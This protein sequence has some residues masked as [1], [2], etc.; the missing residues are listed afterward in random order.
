MISR[1]DQWEWIPIGSEALYQ[2]RWQTYVDHAKGNWSDE[3]Q[4]GLLRHSLRQMIGGIAL[5]IRTMG[6]SR[7][8]HTPGAAQ[9][10]LAEMVLTKPAEATEPSVVAIDPYPTAEVRTVPAVIRATASVPER[11][12]VA[13]QDTEPF[14]AFAH[15][16]RVVAP[17]YPDDWG[18]PATREQAVAWL[19]TNPPQPPASGL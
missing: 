19:A 5:R 3:V 2:R 12:V 1:L 4:P 17:N 6:E 10:R 14:D 9:Q 18:L 7:G 11:L 13:P 8:R 15:P 16:D